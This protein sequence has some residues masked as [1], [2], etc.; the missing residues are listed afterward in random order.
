MAKLEL[1]VLNDTGILGLL[2]F[3]A[4]AVAVARAPWL[5]RRNPAVAGLGMAIW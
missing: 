2:A 1:S 5:R 3:S 4:F